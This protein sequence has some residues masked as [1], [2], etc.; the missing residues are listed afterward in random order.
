MKK[1]RNRVVPFTQYSPPN[2]R[3]SNT[4]AYVDED[5]WEIAKRVLD[6]GAHFDAE[7]LSTADVSLTCELDSRDNPLLAIG[8]AQ[9]GPGIEAV[10]DKLIRDAAA[11][12]DEESG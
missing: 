8:L 6:S 10:V 5:T 11:K 1:P 2:G 7:I 3:R 4:G 12:L 9:N